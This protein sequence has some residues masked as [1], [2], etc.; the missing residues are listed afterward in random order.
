MALC[1]SILRILLRPKGMIVD[2]LVTS[3][4]QH[5]W[6]VCEGDELPISSSQQSRIEYN[7]L[8]KLAQGG[9]GDVYLQESVQ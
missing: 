4:V 2:I 7:L 8:I 5:V 1:L 6:P 9:G 3:V